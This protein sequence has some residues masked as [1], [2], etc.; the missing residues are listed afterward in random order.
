MQF[1]TFFTL[2]NNK[3]LLNKIKI[4]LREREQESVRR[5]LT[6][7]YSDVSDCGA[8][9][10][11][12]VINTR[13]LILGTWILSS[14]F[15]FSFRES[16]ESTRGRPPGNPFLRHACDSVVPGEN[17]S[18]AFLPSEWPTIAMRSSR[19]R[20]HLQREINIHNIFSIRSNLIGTVHRVPAFARRINNVAVHNTCAM[21]ASGNATIDMRHA[22]YILV[23]IVETSRRCCNNYD[24]YHGIMET[25]I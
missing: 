3:L 18:S 20:R 9:L 6:K 15:S 10:L 21:T 23:R 5:F 13:V 4:S 1:Q 17:R 16:D 7:S 8:A 12:A 22:V 2:N 14:W 25:E 11:T 19:H 24:M